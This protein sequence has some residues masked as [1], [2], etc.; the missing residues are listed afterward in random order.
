TWALVAPRAGSD[1]PLIVRLAK[2]LDRALLGSMVWV[3]DAT[4][5]RVAGT[6][7]V[8]GG[9]RVGTFAPAKPWSRGE[10]RLGVDTR[11]EGG[12]GDRGLGVDVSHPIQRKIETKTVERRFAV[13]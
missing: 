13:R 2:P 11:L 10:Y 7:T 5:E 3:A 4:G 8:G 1:S 9:E 6:V 12:G